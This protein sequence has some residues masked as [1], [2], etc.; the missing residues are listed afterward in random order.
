MQMVSIWEHTRVSITFCFV[1]P[2]IPLFAPPPYI[3]LFLC[4]EK[5]GYHIG[6]GN[7]RNT[8]APVFLCALG[9]LCIS[10]LGVLVPP[11][12]FWAEFEIGSIADPSKELAH[13]WPP[14]NIALTKGLIMPYCMRTLLTCCS[15]ILYTPSSCCFALAAKVGFNLL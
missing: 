3:S 11:S 15:I 7:F 5:G 12:M 10:V 8:H 6:L 9:G 4:M 2:V 14:V 1:A 13:I